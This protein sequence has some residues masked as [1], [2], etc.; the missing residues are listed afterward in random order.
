MTSLHH[1]RALSREASTHARDAC[2]H[3]MADRQSLVVANFTQVL[4]VEATVV[5]PG[6]VDTDEESAIKVQAVVAEAAV[7]GTAGSVVSGQKRRRKAQAD[8]AMTADEARAQAERE[9]LAFV[10]STANLTGYYGVNH[11]PRARFPYA[12]YIFDRGKESNWQGRY[13]GSY[14]TA[15]EGALAYARATNNTVER[16]INPRKVLGPKEVHTRTLQCKR[17]GLLVDWSCAKKFARKKKR[18]ELHAGDGCTGNRC[19]DR[20]A[21]R[22]K[23][24]RSQMKCAE[25][26]L[27][28]ERK[29]LEWPKNVNDT[30]AIP[31]PV[32]VARELATQL[33]VR[34]GKPEK[35]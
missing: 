4:E 26:L 28:G 34:Q 29:L 22:L 23:S 16:T 5:E 12:V 19:G 24:A 9:G 7:Q 35:C 1:G 17:C 18:T 6:R 32:E 31:R 21:S 11:D 33:L 2:K 14:S 27:C 3:S 25:Q 13:I 10:K 20:K 15:E 8:D 30:D